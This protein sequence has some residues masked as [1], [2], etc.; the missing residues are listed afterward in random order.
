[1]ELEKVELSR[2]LEGSHLLRKSAEAGFHATRFLPKFPWNDSGSVRMRMQ[3]SRFMSRT[4]QSATASW[5]TSWSRKSAR[6]RSG[7]RSLRTGGGT[8]STRRRKLRIWRERKPCR[9][10]RTNWRRSRQEPENKL[11]W[12]FSPLRLSGDSQESREE[13]RRLGGGEEA[14]LNPKPQTGCCRSCRKSLLPPPGRGL[15]RLLRRSDRV[16]VD[17]RPWTRGLVYNNKNNGPA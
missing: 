12:R 13:D 17:S 5:R 9:K 7:S 15:P 16:G 11:M 8:T 10:S 3:S 2:R 1:M 14:V 4:W 6:L